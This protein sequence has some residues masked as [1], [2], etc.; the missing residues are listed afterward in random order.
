MRLPRLRFGSGNP[1]VVISAHF[2]SPPGEL[3]QDSTL[4]V[5]GFESHPELGKLGDSGAFS[6]ILRRWRGQ[7]YPDN[8][9]N[10]P[11]VPEFPAPL[12]WSAELCRLPQFD[13]ISLRVMQTSEAPNAWIRFR[14][15]DFNSCRS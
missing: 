3:A 9:V 15:F 14:V 5:P 1:D 13:G 10:V 8:D 6:D 7:F 12:M 2:F 11:S 4:F